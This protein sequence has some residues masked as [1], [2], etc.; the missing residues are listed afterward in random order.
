[1]S[2][3]SG[4]P[5]KPKKRIETQSTP[6]FKSIF[7]EKLGA[8]DPIPE[9]DREDH[10]SGYEA[11]GIKKLKREVPAILFFTEKNNEAQFADLWI[12]DPEI[13][14]DDFQPHDEVRKDLARFLK[15]S[16]GS[17]GFPKLRIS[18]TLL[19][20]NEGRLYLLVDD[21]RAARVTADLKDK[22]IAPL[23]FDFL[24]K[25]DIKKVAG[26]FRETFQEDDG[27]FDRT[28]SRVLVNQDFLGEK[29]ED[30]QLL[31]IALKYKMTNTQFMRFRIRAKSAIDAIKKGKIEEEG[32][33]IL[34]G[35]NLEDIAR[36]VVNDDNE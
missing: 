9:E 5:I 26:L 33:Q 36:E 22:V 23:L 2:I 7:L 27:E 35:N 3:E 8:I 24:Q 4:K 32:A 31:N 25:Y 12:T 14:T 17:E 13:I 18:A 15:V 10:A 1:M 16:E 20:D 11:I 6:D 30:L 29:R 34:T 21:Q 19:Q 28:I